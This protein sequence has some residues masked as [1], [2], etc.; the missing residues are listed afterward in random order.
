MKGPHTLQG[1]EE[2]RAWVI[3]AEGEGEGEGSVAPTPRGRVNTVQVV[4][5]RLG[6]RLATAGGRDTHRLPWLS[7]FWSS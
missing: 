4:G 6:G 5:A 2:E 1:R 7:W 3:E